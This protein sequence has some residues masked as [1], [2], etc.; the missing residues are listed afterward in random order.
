M[1]KQQMYKNINTVPEA[2]D[3]IHKSKQ[4]KIHIH[5]CQTL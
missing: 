3:T 2:Q 4:D 5:L 1:E